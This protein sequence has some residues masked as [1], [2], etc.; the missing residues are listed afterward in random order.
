M[1]FDFLRSAYIK[2]SSDFKGFFIYFIEAN[3]V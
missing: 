1:A 2:I 3:S